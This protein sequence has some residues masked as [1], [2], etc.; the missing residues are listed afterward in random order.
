MLR[1]GDIKELNMNPWAIWY[2]QILFPLIVT[3]SSTEHEVEL[4]LTSMQ[5]LHHHRQIFVGNIFTCLQ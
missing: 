1:V 4:E 2:E 3:H 5:I